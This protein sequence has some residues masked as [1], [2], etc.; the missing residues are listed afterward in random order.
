M[1]D[2]KELFEQLNTLTT[3]RRNSASMDI[4]S[5]STIE[6]LKLINDED[7]RVAFAV[8]Q[9]LSYIATAVE[10]VTQA[11][12][13]GGRLFYAGAGTSGR[14]GVQDAAECPPTFELD[15]RTIQGMI[16]GGKLG[17]I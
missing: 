14:I 17:I 12:K 7:K 9:E 4:D 1:A 2:Q 5:K 13:S 8:E 11:F 15:P 10:I 3:E 16:A 6:I